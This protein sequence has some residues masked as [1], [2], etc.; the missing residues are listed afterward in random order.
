MFAIVIAI[1]V[2]SIMATAVGV[3]FY[4]VFFWGKKHSLRWWFARHVQ[5]WLRMF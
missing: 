1:L 3:C 4:G 5:P 2:C